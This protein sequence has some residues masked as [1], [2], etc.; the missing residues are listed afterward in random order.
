MVI[1]YKKSLQS[2]QRTDR[3]GTHILRLDVWY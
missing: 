2:L 3:K 1:T